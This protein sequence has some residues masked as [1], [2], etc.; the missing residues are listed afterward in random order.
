MDTIL[1]IRD[2]AVEIERDD[3]TT[4]AL[5]GVDLSISPGESVGIVGESGCGKTMLALAVMGLLPPGGRV[6]R[7]SIELDGEEL[8]PAS[9][10][11]RAA[12][13][14]DKVAMIFQDP[15]SAL[16]PTMTIGE[17]VAEA[18]LHHRKVSKRAAM[19][20]AIECLRLVG[21]P[22]PGERAHDYPH[23]LSGGQR[24]RVL[25]ASAISCDPKLLIADEPTTALDVTVQA[26]I[27]DLLDQLR[28]QLDMSLILVT[29]DL[30]VVSGRVDR[31]LTM[32]AG[33]I[34]EF[35]PTAELFAQPR[36]RYL[37]ALLQSIPER[38]VASETRL[39]SIPGRPPD[40]RRTIAGCSFAPRCGFATPECRE[41]PPPMTQSGGHGWAC[42]HPVAAG[43]QEALVMS[44]RATR[45]VDPEATTVLR[46]DKV[47][48]D[49]PVRGGTP[50]L[51]RA[52]VS[53]LAGIDLTVDEGE[54]VGILGESGCG[55]TTLGRV[56]V[57]LERPTS[58]RVEVMGHDL[59]AE[60]GSAL[61]RNRQA[62]QMV[63]QD[64]V[65]ALDPRMTVG[66]S[67]S[68]PM[69]ISGRF[70]RSQRRRR[71][72][73]LLDAVGL[74]GDVVRRYP[75]EFSGGQRQRINLARA[76]ALEPALVVADEPVSALD[77]SVQSQILN[78]LDD[79]RREQNLAMLFISHDL[80]VVR[81]LADRIGVMFL[82]KLVEI[83]PA[84]D[85]HESCR[86]PYTR[87][88]VEAVPSL[89]LDRAGAEHLVIERSE[90]SALN[91]PSGCRFRLNCPLATDRCAEEEP[92]LSGVSHQVACHYPLSTEAERGEV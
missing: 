55:K 11:Q 10:R 64:S 23:R 52:K 15:L 24:Q 14:G 25:I 56:A 6:S 30:G 4:H 62:A 42:V 13:R 90:V 72:A 84:K 89:D 32:Y 37:E 50:L 54:T 73:E 74:A 9:G 39:R 60:R 8:V 83:G 57:A 40:L 78:L 59:F 20:R 44:Q 48:K 81:Y 18:V 92:V 63:F 21:I 75:H 70:S 47:V 79:V 7:G 31:V 22:S 53:A 91:P 2:V 5:R 80:S 82:G 34:V 29:H 68:E 1:R 17:Q 38:A 41:Q 51:S 33:Q 66:A 58:G 49:F 46:M 26:Q 3:D 43:S 35:A 76:L 19:E 87:A 12:V 69:V 65:A 45:P 86:H 67:L 85:V 36:H 71:V 16:N 28:A 77:V 88:L 27:L 61:R